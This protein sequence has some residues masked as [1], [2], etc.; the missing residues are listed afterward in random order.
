MISNHALTGLYH[1]KKAEDFIETAEHHFSNNIRVNNEFYI[2]PMYNY[3]IE[4]GRKFVIDEV[5]EHF[6]LG[7]PAELQTFLNAP[8]K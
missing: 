8:V 7:T 3:L 4:K 6:I 1:F 2:A 5:S